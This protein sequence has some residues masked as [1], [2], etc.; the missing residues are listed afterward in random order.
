M[1]KTNRNKK[2]SLRLFIGMLIVAV[3]TFFV[4]CEENEELPMDQAIS[5][6][7]I[8]G[9]YVRLNATLV[10]SDS[11]TPQRFATLEIFLG[12]E[13]QLLED[14]SFKNGTVEGSWSKEGQTLFLYTTAGASMQLGIEEMDGQHLELSHKYR[15]Y[16]N[17]SDGTVTYTFVKKGSEADFDHDLLSSFDTWLKKL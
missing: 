11:G 9:D 6:S 12:D 3:V 2:G 17:Y 14:S 8:I 16:D 4:S 13:L 7:S 1:K 15:S 5:E 10:N